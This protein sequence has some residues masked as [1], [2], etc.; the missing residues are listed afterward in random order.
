MGVTFTSDPTPG[1]HT[2]GSA[3]WQETFGMKFELPA[4]VPKDEV[5]IK[6]KG[7]EGKGL[8][9]AHFSNAHQA[10]N[11]L[12]LCMFTA[13]TGP[14]P[15]VEFV[16]ALTG[17]DLTQ[18]DLLVAGERIQNLRAAF[19][20]REG[21]RPTD[22]QAHPRMIGEGDGNLTAG[23]LKGV[24]VPLKV[25]RDD[26]YSAMQWNPETGKLA[27]SRAEKLGIAPLLDG[28]LDG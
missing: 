10:M 24:R 6:W 15:W 19:N 2:A 28:Y 4:A 25:L 20:W 17:W 9:Q 22:F 5:S 7:T 1:R 13:L 26:Y 21:H 18:N 14:L 23:P 16:N 27:R 3:S 12:G 11:G 8:A